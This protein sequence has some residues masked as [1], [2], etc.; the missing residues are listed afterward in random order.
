MSDPIKAQ[1]V[2]LGSGPAGYSR[3]LRADLGL[4]TVIIERFSSL[5]GVCLNVGCIPSKALLHVAKVIKD[6]RDLSA[7]GVEFGEPQIDLAKV[8]AWKEKVIGQLTK[9]LGGMAKLRKCRIV[10]GYGKFT[11]P[12]TI[13]VEGSEDG[14]VEVT[15]E[16]AIIAAGSK[17]IQPLS[18]TIPEFGIPPTLWN[19][20]KPPSD[21]CSLAAAS[22]GWKWAWS[23]RRSAQPSRWSR[24]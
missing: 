8:R 11:G 15:F 14:P 22:S 2:V 7:H 4:D 18:A 1:V 10:N 13:A 17:P 5:G 9:G 20:G 24:C 23:I 19:Y 6:A 3:C 16:H 12:N 21:C